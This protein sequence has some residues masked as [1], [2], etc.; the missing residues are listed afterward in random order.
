MESLFFSLYSSFYTFFSDTATL[1]KPLS[2]APYGKFGWNF[3]PLLASP[4]VQKVNVIESF[5][6]DIYVIKESKQTKMNITSSIN[7]SNGNS[8]RW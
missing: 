2:T 7:Q 8:I 4:Y 6:E 1:E 5:H 3:F